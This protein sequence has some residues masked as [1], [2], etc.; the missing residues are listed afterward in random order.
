MKQQQMKRTLLAALVSGIFLPVGA[1][2]ATKPNSSR[3]S[4]R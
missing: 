4:K 3:N 2:A 1:Q